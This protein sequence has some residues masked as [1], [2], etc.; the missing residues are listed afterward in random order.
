[1]GPFKHE[2][3]PYKKLSLRCLVDVVEKTNVIG[4]I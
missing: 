2:S 1:M 3:N 4:Y